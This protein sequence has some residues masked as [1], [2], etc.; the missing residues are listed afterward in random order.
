MSNTRPIIPLSEQEQADLDEV[1]ARADVPEE[2]ADIKARHVK[3][4]I[5]YCG[6]L[7]ARLAPYEKAELG[8]T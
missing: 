6:N 3:A 8:I 1:L 7:E 4:L 5:K 2:H